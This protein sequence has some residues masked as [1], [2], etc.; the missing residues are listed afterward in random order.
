MRTSLTLGGITLTRTRSG[1]VRLVTSS[2][3]EAWLTRREAV[4]LLGALN[5]LPDVAHA[6]LHGG[7]R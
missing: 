6:W 4:E 5:A 3:Q 7:G 2:G 1:A